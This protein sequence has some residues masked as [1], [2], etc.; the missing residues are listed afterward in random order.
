MAMQ[1]YLEE[2]L[3]VVLKSSVHRKY[4]AASVF[5]CPPSQVHPR[6]TVT[7]T[8]LSTALP[9]WEQVFWWALLQFKQNT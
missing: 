1:S 2:K 8:Q 9:P 6:K 4:S 3:Q 5:Y 7:N